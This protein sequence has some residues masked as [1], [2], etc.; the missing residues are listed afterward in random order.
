MPLGMS[1][2]V[3]SDAIQSRTSSYAL[4]KLAA[5]SLVMCRCC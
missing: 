2:P 4:A 3:E 5:A 1:V